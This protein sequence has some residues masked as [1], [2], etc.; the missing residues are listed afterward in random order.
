MRLRHYSRVRLTFA[1]GG[2]A[3]TAWGTCGTEIPSEVL[4]LEQA[5]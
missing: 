1:A 2:T 4:G 5:P 3:P